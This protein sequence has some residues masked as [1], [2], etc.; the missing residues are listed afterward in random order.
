[1]DKIKSWIINHKLEFLFL[2]LIL[3]VGAFCRL[4]KIDQYMTFL[5]DKGRDVIIV[6]RIFTELHPPLIGPGTSIGNMYL[7]PLYYYM[8]AIPLLVA[9]F[10][11]VGPAIFIALLGIVTIFFVWFVIREWFPP[12]E[13][14]GTCWG[15]L[16]AA[17][18][19]AISPVVIIY[20]RSSWNP[21]IMPFFSL[22]TIYG[23][24]RVWIKKELKWL[25]VVGISFACVLQS[26]YLGLLL[27]PVI[28]IIWFL[29]LI[30]TEKKKKLIRYS[31][32]GIAAFLILMSP[33]LFFDLRHNFQ[34]F[35]AMKLFFT[36][37]Q[38]TVSVL[39]WK[40]I[41][42][43]WPMLNNI[44]TDLVAAKNV[45]VGLGVAA[46]IT[47]Y[48]IYVY[49]VKREKFDE[50]KMSVILILTLWLGFGLIGLGLYKQNIY[51]HYYGFLFVLPFITIG[52]IVE[53]NKKLLFRLL[54]LA[55]ILVLVAVDL[56]NSPLRFAPNMQLTRSRDI[57]RLIYDKAEGQR[58]NLATI[59]ERNNRDVYQYFLA[60]WG[61][62][63]VDVDPNA[64]QY[65]VTDQ[66]FVVCE[67]DIKKC[68]PTHDPSAWITGF[69][70][71]KIVDSWNV[72]GVNVIKLGHAK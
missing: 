14:Q 57:A 5:G 23:I 30:K 48:F 27:L 4:Y 8:M 66:L 33:L 36:D 52:G 11:P 21:N 7:G 26:H 9:N 53:V 71:S 12:V 40:A 35:K 2:T 65:T 17:F 10:N 29:V 41:P 28:G 64:T 13:G 24:W 44:T 45:Q 54:L 67:K 15:A 37:R 34:N 38:T 47:L 72:D 43:M 69:G 32:I 68:D 55:G 42:D 16:V 63:V 62:K 3:L 18:L 60:V 46:A 59:S 20:S 19:Y 50:K 58:F 25:V 39:P 49:L 6:R 22:L 61:A 31:V 51:D 56:V 70:W 1:M